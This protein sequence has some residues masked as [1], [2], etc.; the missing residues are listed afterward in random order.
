[1]LGRDHALLGAL[2]YLVVAPMVLHDPSWQALGVGS[3][4]SGA[5]A[6]LPDLDEPGSTVSSKLGFISRMVSQVTRRVAGGHREG[7]HSLLFVAL[8]AA[9][10]YFA[11][12]H[13][14]AVGIIVAASFALVF[15]MLMPMVVRHLPLFWF[16]S[17]DLLIASGYWADHIAAAS[18][19]HASPSTMWLFLATVGGVLFH[20]AGDACTIDGVP[21]VWLPLV[22]ITRRIRIAVPIV[23]HT[24]SARESLLGG[25]MGLGVLVLGFVLVAR[26]AAHEISSV[27]F[28]V[29]V[30]SYLQ[31][32]LRHHR[33]VFHIPNP[34]R[35]VY[36]LKHVKFV[37]SH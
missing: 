2:G 23:G 16:F 17:L 33:F 22:R 30:W 24:G 10:T 13:P 5:F 4:T 14:L 21:L 12:G 15:R 26:P 9:G 29:P 37:S 25:L 18:H 36:N 28:Q 3:V 19:G 27:R 34:S 20:L 7:T 31:T 8:V 11:L 32:I 1:M 35:L 6:L